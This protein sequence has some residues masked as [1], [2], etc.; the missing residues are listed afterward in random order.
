MATS[1]PETNSTDHPPK[2]RWAHGG[3]AWIVAYVW[4][5]SLGTGAVT[6]GIFFLTES[7][8]GYG[9]GLNLLLG[10]LSHAAYVPGAL[11]VGPLIRRLARRTGITP[12]TVLTVLTASLGGV[13][14]APAIVAATTAEPGPPPAWTIWLVAMIYAPLTGA[15][16][17]LA[18]SYVSGGRSGPRLTKA[19]GAFNL[20]WASAMIAAAWLMAPLVEDRPIDVLTLL[21]VVHLATAG[22]LTRF[23]RAPGS[24]ETGH[25]HIDPIARRELPVF[26]VLLPA[27]YIVMSTL[28]PVLSVS[29]AGLGVPRTWRPPLAGVWLITRVIA[30]VVLHRWHG[31]YGSRLLAPLSLAALL[32]AFAGALLGPQL[33]PGP[34]ALTVVV[35]SLAVLGVA[36]AAIYKASLTYVMA[37]SDSDVDAGGTHEALIG[38]GYTAGPLAGAGAAWAAGG[39]GLAADAAVVLAV[40]G[41]MI[42]VGAWALVRRAA[43]RDHQI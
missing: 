4:L 14:V 26:R 16:W 20:S 25:K 37:G 6:D 43:P 10:V 11:L 28:T 1:P 39:S 27:S 3:L 30:F 21:G 8:Y 40:S 42:G 17:P 29:L 34:A 38:L 32:A 19:V 15:L 7:A 9:R 18:E 5:V 24:H 22:L 31:W 35:G 33:G 41:L 36:Q 12:R 13:C 23:A 2:R